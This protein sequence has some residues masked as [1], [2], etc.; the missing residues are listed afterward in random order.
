MA[1]LQSSALAILLEIDVT[2]TTRAVMQ[3]TVPSLLY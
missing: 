1:R 3:A 2:G